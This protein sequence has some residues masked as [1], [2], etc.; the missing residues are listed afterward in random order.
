[1][2]KSVFSLITA[3]VVLCF[4]ANVFAQ[5]D[6]T[7]TFTFTQVFHSPSYS[8]TKNVLAVWIQTSSGTFVKTK[9]RRV[10]NQTKDHLPTW[11]VN[12]GGSASNA[13]SANCNTTDATTGATLTSFSTHTIV[14]DGK[15]V[16][17]TVNGTTVADGV[18]KVTIQ[19]TWNHG[20]TRTTTRSY[21]FTKGAVAD[22]Q[23]PADD[24]DFSGM[25]LDWIPASVGI[26]TVDGKPAIN[27]FPNPNNNG[28]F[29]VEFL[30][31]NNIKVLNQMGELVYNENVEA[32]I[33]A[34]TIDLSA[35]ANGIYFIY[36]FDGDKSTKHEVILAK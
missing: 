19:E 2:K 6:G 27:I 35:N 8:G 4:S 20:S 9:L 23:T 16:N 12:S 15:G 3:A 14:W 18:Y 10:G 33:T 28:I 34:K 31:S 21:T 5:T 22:H 29:N 1:M 17:G 26:E 30:K 32:G 36:I 13:M 25:T 11:A 24:A 7:L